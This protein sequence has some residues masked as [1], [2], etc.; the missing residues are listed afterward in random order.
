MTRRVV[1]ARPYRGDEELTPVGVRPSVS[2]G[3]G[4]RAI[5]PQVARDLI[6]ELATPD[7]DAAC[8]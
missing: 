2:H 1:S 7:R 4:V 6:L 8:V 5:V 3:D